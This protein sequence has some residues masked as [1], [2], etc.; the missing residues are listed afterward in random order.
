[1]SRFPIAATHHCQHLSFHH[2]SHAKSSP[3][4]RAP[5]LAVWAQGTCVRPANAKHFHTRA[6]SHRNPSN[7]LRTTPTLT[8][9]RPRCL[10][11]QQS[12]NRSG[13]RIGAPG[14]LLRVDDESTAQR[15]SCQPSRAVTKKPVELLRTVESPP[16]SS[17]VSRFA[18]AYAYNM[19]VIAL[20]CTISYYWSIN[21]RRCRTG[22]V[23]PAPL[24]ASICRLRSG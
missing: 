24:R 22:S 12:V 16:N 5:A 14:P 20:Q 8:R 23:V 11:T 4:Y 19:C 18:R 2:P 21:T 13:T 1:M 15:Q 9:Q 10:P 17:K 6:A 3:N 7:T